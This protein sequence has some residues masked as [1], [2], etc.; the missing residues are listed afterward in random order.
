MSASAENQSIRHTPVEDLLALVAGCIFMALSVAFYR[1][2]GLLTGGTT[3]LA[4]IFHYVSDW[5]LGVI[6]FLVNLPFYVFSWLAMGPV[7]TLKTFGAVLGFSVMTEYMP[8]FLRLEYMDTFY[9]AIAAGFLAGT[10]ILIF[11]RHGASLGGIGV[12]ALY[13]QKKRGWRAGIIQMG[14]DALILVAGVA[15]VPFQALLLSILSAL[16]LNL[17]IAMNHRQG[18]YFG[19]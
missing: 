12:M 4:F 11:I 5:S 6:L 14:C 16:A 2:A 19:F 9:A 13:L 8:V 3:G 17:V 1:H 18:R 7:F 10:G 15:V